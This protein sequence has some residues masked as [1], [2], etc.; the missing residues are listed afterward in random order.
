MGRLPTLFQCGQDLVVRCVALRVPLAS[1]MPSVVMVSLFDQLV[2]GLPVFQD[3][4]S[5][6]F[7]ICRRR[8]PLTKTSWMLKPF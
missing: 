2:S 5:S 4:L 7:T 1:Y 3:I 6:L 8:W